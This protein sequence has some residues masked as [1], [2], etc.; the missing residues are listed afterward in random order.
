M[1]AT[2]LAP[3]VVAVMVVR[4]ASLGPGEPLDADFEQVLLALAQQD[5]PR[6]KCLFLLVGPAGVDHGQL[7]DRIRSIVPSAFVRALDGNPGFGAAANEAARLVQGNGVFC[8]LHDDVALEPNVISVLAEELA[9]SNA[10]IVGPKLVEWD[11]PDLLQSVGLSVDRFGETDS[12]VEPGEVDQ[13]QHDGVRDVFA[14][15]SACLMIRADLFTEVGG[16][17]PVIEYSGDDVDLCWR[18]HLAGARV[19]VVANVRA[20]HR[21][22]LWVRRPDLHIPGLAA[23]ARMRSV[24]TLTGGARLFWVVPQLLLLTLAE[25]VVGAL[26]GRVRDALVSVRSLVGMV[27]RTGGYLARRRR[28]APLRHVPDAEVASLQA[29]GS[30]RLVGYLRTRERSGDAEEGNERRWRQSAG[31]A[32]LLALASLF[33]L[34]ALGSRAV[35]SGGLPGVGQIV[36]FPSSPWRLATQY[37]SGWNGHGA[38]SSSPAPTGLAIV[39]ILSVFT[40]FHMGALHTLSIVGLVVAGALGAWRMAA[41]FPTARARIAV[42]VAYGA[43]P[44][45]AGLMSTGRLSALVVYA[46]MP[47]SVHFLRRLAGL[48]TRWVDTES[49]AAVADGVRPVPLEKRR[50]LFARLVVVTA[51]AAAFAPVFPLVLV[52]VAIVLALATLLAGGLHRPALEMVLA[53]IA[54]LAAAFVLHLPWSLTFIGRGGLTSLVGVERVSGSGVGVRRLLEMHLGSVNL[55]TF[56]LALLVPVFVAPLVARSWRFA[57]AVRGGALVAVFGVLAVIDDRQAL[58]FHLPEPGVLLVPVAIGVSIAVGCIAAAFETDV[59]SGSFGWRQPIGLVAAVASVIG[60]VPGLLASTGGR[61]GMP[62]HTLQ[63]ALVQLPR[64]STDATGVV[65]EADQ[66][67]LWIGEPRA[68]PAAAAQL[69]P[70]IGYAIT[71]L[72]GTPTRADLF[73]SAWPAPSDTVDRHVVEALRAMR[74][75]ATNRV[76]RLLA[77]FAIR[78]VLVPLADGAVGTLDHPIEPPSGL[79]EVLDGQLDLAAP[80]SRPPNFLVYENTAFA[81]VRSVLSLSGAEASHKAG[82]ASIAQADLS[83][84]IGFPADGGPMTSPTSASGN[85]TPGTLHVAVPYSS[86][87]HLTV[88]GATVPARLAFGATVAFDVKAAGPAHLWYDR[89]W[90][91]LLWVLLQA[92]AWGATLWIATRARVRRRRDRWVYDPSAWADPTTPIIDLDRTDGVPR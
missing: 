55:P 18:A 38:G 5:H 17:D 48:D 16:F 19:L 74:D 47:W 61:W 73:A 9:Q 43:C 32:R 20:R 36:P 13:G 42:L 75:G 25:A 86:D 56:G 72:G 71:D 83:G 65:A 15:P 84:S 63:A 11:A 30:A 49:I 77:P 31:G 45:P 34:V 67:V 90:S 87:W 3:A 8:F 37:V 62:T 10:G 85:V 64:A 39:A 4:Q 53:S 12:F 58:P 57:W 35:L 29:R 66:R 50:W 44:L 81:P 89:P 68:I 7:P 40:L 88:G 2:P 24:A 21:G 59:L 46:A 92:V 52:A 78:F 51:L 76:G 28:L 22:T 27:P 69:A 33:A 91:R 6:L 54:A 26:T 82:A 79:A 70:G 23:R 80:L 41:V 1:E 60:V 14:I